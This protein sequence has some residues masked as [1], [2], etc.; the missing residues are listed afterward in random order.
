MRSYWQQEQ[1]RKRLSR[2]RWWPAVLR[3]LHATVAVVQGDC[4]AAAAERDADSGAEKDTLPVNEE[5]ADAAG[6]DT[7]SR[8]IVA[9]V[10]AQ[11][12][13]AAA[14][15]WPRH[16]SLTITHITQEA[17]QNDTEDALRTQDTGTGH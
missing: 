3:Q 10:D 13:I 6:H 12:T 17:D 8:P 14:V 9:D 15:S 16:D 1:V 5:Q 11:G 4:A 7:Q 2:R